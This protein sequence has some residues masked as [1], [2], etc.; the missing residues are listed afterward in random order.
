MWHPEP[1]RGTVSVCNKKW[2]RLPSYIIRATP[3][4]V[5]NFT[6]DNS[7]VFSL[8]KMLVAEKEAKILIKTFEAS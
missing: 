8:L 4:D 1:G 6:R 5:D 2:R 3:Y 7:C